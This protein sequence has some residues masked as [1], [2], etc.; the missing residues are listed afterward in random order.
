MK[1]RTISVIVW[2]V[3]LLLFTSLSLGGPSGFRPPSSETVEDQLADSLDCEGLDQEDPWDHQSGHE[4]E[5]GTPNWGNV[6]LL[7]VNNTIVVV[8]LN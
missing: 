8:I 2:V 5:P 1:R 6:M 3:L 7:V 4:G